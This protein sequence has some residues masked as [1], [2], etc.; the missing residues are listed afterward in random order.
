MPSGYQS[1]TSVQKD[2]ILLRIKE[3]GESV[4]ILALEYA[5]N[6][7]V[8]YHLLSRST[9]SSSLILEN[10]RLKREHDALVKIIGELFIKGATGAQKKIRSCYGD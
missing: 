6:K 3:K 9:T 1:L 2:E 7:R 8:I 5:C 4:S 10:A